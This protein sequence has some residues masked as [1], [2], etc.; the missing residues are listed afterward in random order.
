MP[1]GH[2]QGMADINQHFAL[3][4]ACILW[5]LRRSEGFDVGRESTADQRGVAAYLF[6]GLV[7]DGV[8]PDVLA[9]AL[10]YPGH[11]VVLH[12]QHHPDSAHGKLLGLGRHCSPTSEAGHA[13]VHGRIA[14]IRHAVEQFSNIYAWMVLAPPGV[15][16]MFVHAAARLRMRRFRMGC[17]DLQAGHMR[18]V[19]M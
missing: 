3:A 13:F 4:A 8:C 16:G 10:Q 18:R 2:S 15:T 6:K 19:R 12:P 9:P 7:T 11:H 14:L 1:G 17:M 5:L